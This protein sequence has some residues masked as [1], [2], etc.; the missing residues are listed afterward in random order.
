MSKPNRVYSHGF[1]VA[2]V[3][4]MEAASNIKAFA[5]QIG[6]QRELLYLWRSKYRAEGPAGL[7]GRGR[8]K[9]GSGPPDP[10]PAPAVADPAA[11][12]AELERKVGQQAL[13]LDFFRA[14]LKHF[15]ATRR[16]NGEAGETGS[17]P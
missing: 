1:K 11:R 17:T 12:I 8:P 2:A 14:A 7:R 9:P 6:V 10:S 13:E 4:G 16:S 5:Q 15:E 3:A